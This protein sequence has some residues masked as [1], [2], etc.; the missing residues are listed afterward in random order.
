V[1]PNQ[2]VPPV[3]TT[4]S[5]TPP[6]LSVSPPPQERKED[7]EAMVEAAPAPPGRRSILRDVAGARQTPG[8]AIGNS[9]KSASRTQDCLCKLECPAIHFLF[10]FV[11]EC[12]R[13]KVFVRRRPENIAAA[14]RATLLKTRAQ[15][16]ERAAP[17]A[18]MR[19]MLSSKGKLAS[20]AL[21]NGAANGEASPRATLAPSFAAKAIDPKNLA[22]FKPSPAE[23]PLIDL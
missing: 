5:Y 4:P 1:A 13:P 16:P 2:N 9:P 6:M 14:I 19:Q 23:T 10:R 8:T 17:A 21:S 15:N 11:A 18:L 12:Q 7:V 22:V 20:R 3:S